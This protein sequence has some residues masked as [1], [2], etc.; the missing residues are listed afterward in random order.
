MKLRRQLLSRS[1]VRLLFRR[2]V[3]SFLLILALITINFLLIHLAPGDPAHILAGQ[4]GDAKYYEFIR[5]K[6]GLD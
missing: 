2:T 4:S 1:S 3:Q 5:A 6:F